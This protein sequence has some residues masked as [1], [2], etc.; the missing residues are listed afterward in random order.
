MP[1]PDWV[2]L[3]IAGATLL[4]GLSLLANWWRD[5]HGRG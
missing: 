2:R 1:A 4:V 3:L 5:H